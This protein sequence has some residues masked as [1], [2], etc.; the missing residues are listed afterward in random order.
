[1]DFIEKKS[2]GKLNIALDV[3]RKREDGYH[4]MKMVMQTINIFDIIKIEKNDSKKITISSNKDITEDIENNLIYKACKSVLEGRELF[5]KV[6]L[7]I[8]IEKN[9]PMGAGMA[10]GSANCGTTIIAVNELLNLGLSQEEMLNIGRKLGSDVTYCMVGG[11]KLVEGVG[12]IISDLTPHPSTY[13]LVVKPKVSVSTKEIFGDL[14]LDNIEE[15][16]NFDE[17]IKGFSNKNILQISKYCRNIFEEVTIPKYPII[18][19][20]KDFMNENGAI[21]SLMTGT[22]STVFAYFE[23]DK[24]ASVCCD[25]ISEKFDLELALVTDVV[26]NNNF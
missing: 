16:P 18:K 14:K 2:Y 3:I 22:G 12:D 10:G 25:K 19:E 21:T 20:I 4:D 8:E 11:T 13:L 24:L 9:I 1:M 26:E 6:G 15:R 5:G 7:H 23:N 17:I